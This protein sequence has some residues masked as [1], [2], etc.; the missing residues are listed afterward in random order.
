MILWLF[1]PVILWYENRP[2]PVGSMPVS[3]CLAATVPVDTIMVPPG[4]Y[5]CEDDVLHVEYAKVVDFLGV[6]FVQLS[7]GWLLPIGI[8]LCV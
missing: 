1:A 4:W 8:G 3:R 5:H 2:I 7:S 6:C